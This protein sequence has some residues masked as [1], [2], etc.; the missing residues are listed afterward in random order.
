MPWSS[1]HDLVGLV[2][3]KTGQR[4]WVLPPKA[5]NVGVRQEE[6]DKGR[7]KGTNQLDRW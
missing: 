4:M 1:S 6:G 5:C 7:G 3:L 2:M